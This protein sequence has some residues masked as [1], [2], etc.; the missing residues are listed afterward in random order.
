VREKEALP[1]ASEPVDCLVAAEP[2]LIDAGHASRW[3]R[4]GIRVG[5]R[6]ASRNEM[7]DVERR[8]SDPR[9]RAAR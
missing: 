2:G 4:V 7:A 6:D 5:N 9:G 8:T 1:Q 3:L